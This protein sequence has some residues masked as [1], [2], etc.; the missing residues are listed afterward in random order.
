MNAHFSEDFASWPQEQT[1]FPIA[2][3]DL[4]VL[5]GDHPFYVAE[6]EAIGENW[7]KETAANPALFDGRMIFQKRLALTENGIAGESHIV[8]FSTFMWWRRQPHR[9]G[10][11]HLFAYPVLATADGAL[12][13]IRMGPHTANPG[14]VY[15]AAGSLE[16]QDVVDEHCDIEANM[17]REVL[18]ETGLD[19]NDAKPGD[20]YFA[21]RIMRTVTV[22]RLFRFDLTADEM[23]AKIHAHMLVA[24]DK[25]IA[26]AVAIRSAD[27]TAQ[28]YNV[29]MLPIIDWYF[30]GAAKSSF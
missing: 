10:G 13:A 15:F 5:P 16:P 14:Q 19:L 27:H 28:P 11:I 21:S 1:V 25:E 24:E 20:R 29:S 18:E 30:D 12:V 8:R 9:N 7:E 26:G 6:R 4:K 22:L 2:G 3:L 23:V 17:R